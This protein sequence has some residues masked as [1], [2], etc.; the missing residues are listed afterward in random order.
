MGQ[1]N[2]LLGCIKKR[3]E[4]GDQIRENDLRNEDGESRK[5]SSV[6]KKWLL[7]EFESSEE[8]NSE[9]QRPICWHPFQKVPGWVEQGKA[10]L[11]SRIYTSLRK[12][13]SGN[14]CKVVNKRLTAFLNTDNLE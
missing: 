14:A 7:K 12:R 6:A 3:R 4:L 13:S 10:S 5:K 8:R 11:R 2:E 1:A 9:S